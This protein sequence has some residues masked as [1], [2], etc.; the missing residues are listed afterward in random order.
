ME[1][2]EILTPSAP[3]SSCA[4]LSFRVKRSDKTPWQ[5][6][7]AL[8]TEYRIRV[9]PVGEINLNAVRV[10]THVFNGPEQVDHLVEALTQLLEKET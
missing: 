2:I 7:D 8:K 4:M 5:W 9:R 3:A 6:V 10:S 1:R